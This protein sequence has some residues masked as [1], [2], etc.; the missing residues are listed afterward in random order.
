MIDRYLRAVALCN[1]LALLTSHGTMKEFLLRF[2]VLAQLQRFWT[3]GQSY[4]K[5]V[6]CSDEEAT[7]AAQ[8]EGVVTL[9]TF[10]NTDDDDDDE[11]DAAGQRES[12]AA[13]DS[14][15]DLKPSLL[16]S[17]NVANANAK[18]SESKYANL[19]YVTYLVLLVKQC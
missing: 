2:A 4:L 12:D 16:E 14:T 15:V 8:C 13:S 3:D 18:K 9:A 5:V 6:V 19:D 7:N 10:R 1:N 11:E 17:C